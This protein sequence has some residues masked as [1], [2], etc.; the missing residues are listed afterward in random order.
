[1]VNHTETHACKEG[2]TKPSLGMMAIDEFDHS[3]VL[4]GAEISR[5]GDQRT[6]MHVSINSKT[7]SFCVKYEVFFIFYSTSITIST[8]LRGFGKGHHRRH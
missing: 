8:V 7:I 4:E 2:V 1:M 6:E 5:R 3:V